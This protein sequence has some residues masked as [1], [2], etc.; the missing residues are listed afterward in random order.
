MHRCI[1]VPY[2]LGIFKAGLFCNSLLLSRYA[3]GFQIVDIALTYSERGLA[4]IF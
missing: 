4:F 2:I 1:R 3:C